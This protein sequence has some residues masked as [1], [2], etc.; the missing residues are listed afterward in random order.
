MAKSTGSVRP[1]D[2][3]PDS[4]AGSIGRAARARREAGSDRR[5]PLSRERIVAAALKI[6]EDRGL[7][8]LTFHRLGEALG[9]E[10]M[11]IYHHFP[12][13]RHILDAMAE[14]AISGIQ[15]PVASLDPL[16]RLRF[17]GQEYR[18][19]AHRYPKMFQLVALHGFH[20]MLNAISDLGGALP[21][22]AKPPK[23]VVRPKP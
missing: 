3:E 13:K 20:M 9:C 22:E 12:S 21:P 18:A 5:I 7:S 19:M 23:P 8:G 2:A 15:E 17:L 16:A 4:G 14:R 6:V 1:R 10:G 11:S